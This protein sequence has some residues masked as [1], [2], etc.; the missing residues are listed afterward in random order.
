MTKHIALFAGFDTTGRGGLWV[1]DGT[2][3]GTFE[4]TGVS[5]ASGAQLVGLGPFLTVFNSKALFNGFNT[6]GLQGL[7]VTNGT[8]AGTFEVTGINGANTN[9]GVNPTDL[10]LFNGEVLFNGADATGLGLWAT[11]GTAAGTSEL[12]GI[13]GANT[14]GLF[15]TGAAAPSPD[16]TVFNGEVL[17]NGHDAAGSDGLWIT[18]GTAAGTFELGGL[19]DVGISGAYTGGL[20]SVAGTSFASPI[21]LAVF[22]QEV[23]LVGR[24]AAGNFG[25]WVSNGTAAGTFELTGISGAN[26][27]GIF[28]SGFLPDFT[29]FNGEVL[30]AGLS[31]PFHQGLWVT[32]GTAAGTFELGGPDNAGISG[33]FGAG[34]GPRDMALFNGEVLFDGGDATGRDGLWVTNGTAAGTFELGGLGNSGISGAFTGAVGFL[35][36]DL[37]VF[38]GEVLFEALDAAGDRSLWVTNG[39][40]AGTFEVTGISGA[41]T[42]GLDPQDLTPLLTSTRKNDFNDDGISDVAWRNASGEVD[43]WFINNG[44]LSGGSA[45]GS[46]SNVWLFAGTGDLTGNGT[47]DVVWQNAATGEVDAWLITNGNLS[48]GTPIGS[49]A[50]AWQPLGTGDFNGDGTSDIL[51]RNTSTGEVDTWFMSSGRMTGGTAVGVVSSAWQFSGV[52]DFTGSG[53]SD[54]VWHNTAT[55]E[56]DDWLISNGHL[57]GGSAIGF[58][59]SAWQA[60]GTGDFN[61]DGVS[62]VLW[63]NLNTGEVDTWLM[64]NGQMVGGTALGSLSSAWQFAGVGDYT[65]NGTSDVLW[66]N[67]N[68]GEV[69]TWLITNDQL[70]GGSAVSTASTAWTPLVIPTA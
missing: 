41:Y 52:G 62:D 60:L 21:T 20:L 58:A 36:F 27:G 44:Q 7:W 66:R 64:N 55:G 19:S 30:F 1:T 54:V 69:D 38:N 9:S 43:T 12:T 35:P 46:V 29:V 28:A 2:S 47:S 17:F 65:G 22:K 18:N 32:D 42:G 25:L 57:V 39:T 56:V 24:N 3:T 34:L 40:V 61:N 6:F 63:R 70:T 50:N 8:V 68:T 5:G 23:L 53:V 15:Q 49:L 31:A 13:S 14:G 45:P 51:W 10:T 16:F 11:N 59:S 37:T 33:A 4:L 67:V 48:G 26:A